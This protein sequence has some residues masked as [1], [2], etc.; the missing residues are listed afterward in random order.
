MP[1]KNGLGLL[2]EKRTQPPADDDANAG[3]LTGTVKM[4]G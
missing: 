4:N 1:L 3:A 2:L